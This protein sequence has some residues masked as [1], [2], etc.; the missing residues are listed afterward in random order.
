ML[1]LL[2]ATIFFFFKTIF[3]IAK[4]RFWNNRG[5]WNYQIQWTEGLKGKKNRDACI[6]NLRQDTD[7]TDSRVECKTLREPKPQNV[8][9]PL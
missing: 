9:P 3:K 1:T 2:V 7:R 5:D 6:Q 4:K 8:T